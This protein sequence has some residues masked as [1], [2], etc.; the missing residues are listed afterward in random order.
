MKMTRPRPDLRYFSFPKILK[1][2]EFQNIFE[3][4]LLQH[5]TM[6]SN[7]LSE[8]LSS[9]TTR[10]EGKRPSVIVALTGTQ[11]SYSLVGKAGITLSTFFLIS[12]SKRTYSMSYEWWSIWK[13]KFRVFLWRPI[14]I[15]LVYW[16][17]LAAV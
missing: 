7:Y 9:P 15:F 3:H 17:T 13:I 16:G 6:T 4:L 11:V 1:N 2:E 8:Y 5:L 14:H 12:D 10:T